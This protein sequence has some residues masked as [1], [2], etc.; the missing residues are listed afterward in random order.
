MG[1]LLYGC[2]LT[3]VHFLYKIYLSQFLPSHSTEGNES[4]NIKAKREYS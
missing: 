1:V 4:M 2:E 3:E